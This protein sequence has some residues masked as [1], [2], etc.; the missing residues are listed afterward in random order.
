MLFASCAA[1]TE[2]RP[3]ADTP[4]GGYFGAT[5]SMG[6]MVASPNRCAFSF[7][8]DTFVVERTSST[9]PSTVKPKSMEATLRGPAH[10]AGAP[11]K[12][13]V[14]GA[15]LGDA[16][17]IGTLILQ[18]G[19]EQS[20]LDLVSDGKSGAR[21]ISLEFSARATAE[22]NPIKISVTLADTGSGPK[23]QRVDIDS[24]DVA[25]DGE[26]CKSISR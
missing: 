12:V 26:F 9:P 21:D 1:K 24:M 7:L 8:Y 20:K 5:R 19:S 4:S 18:Y 3:T 2:P 22:D 11:V 25:V 17:P 6:A 23:Q 13:V 14:H 16:G 10:I 15:Y